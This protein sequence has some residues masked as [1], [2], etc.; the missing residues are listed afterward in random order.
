MPNLSTCPQKEFPNNFIKLVFFFKHVLQKPRLSFGCNWKK[1][2][3]KKMFKKVLTKM[4]AFQSQ[5]SFLSFIPMP[6]CLLI[7]SMVGYGLFSNMFTDSLWSSP[8]GVHH[9]I[10]LLTYVYTSTK[11]LWVHHTLLK[12]LQDSL[13]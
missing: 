1:P 11:T 6:F 9:S 2:N 4:A 12:F 13:Q 5:T 10:C 3:F 8:H 7:Y